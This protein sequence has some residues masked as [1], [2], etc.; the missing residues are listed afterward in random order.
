MTW[1]VLKCHFDQILD[2]Q[3]FTFSYTLGLS[4]ISCKT[5]I[6]CEHCNARFL[7]LYFRKSI[8]AI[9]PSNRN[10]PDSVIIIS[11]ESIKEV[12]T[13]EDW[14][15]LPLKK[16]LKEVSKVVQYVIRKIVISVH[17]WTFSR[18]DK[19]CLSVLAQNF[20]ITKCLR[21]YKAAR[22]L[23]IYWGATDFTNRTNINACD[24]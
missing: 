20:R 15:G 18:Y 6:Y 19:I 11:C 8:A 4:Q 24:L 14:N 10:T 21:E 23:I 1:R 7:D 9:S 13:G 3:F 5:S 2:I 17:P 12:E 16:N 22:F